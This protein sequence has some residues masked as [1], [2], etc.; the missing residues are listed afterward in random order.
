MANCLRRRDQNIY[1]IFQN[2][3]PW[4]TKTFKRFPSG[5]SIY[6]KELTTNND[7]QSFRNLR[8]PKLGNIFIFFYTEIYSLF[9]VSAKFMMTKGVQNKSVRFTHMLT[10]SN[11][12]IFQKC[13]KTFMIKKTNKNCP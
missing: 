11:V 1:L 13:M 12:Y 6:Q 3:A 4:G 7:H 10:S 2:C 5:R 8:C 9:R